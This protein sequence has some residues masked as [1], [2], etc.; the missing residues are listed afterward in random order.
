MS[1]TIM[2][3]LYLFQLGDSNPN[4]KRD[5]TKNIQHILS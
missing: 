2:I 5:E 4:E 3:L 1:L